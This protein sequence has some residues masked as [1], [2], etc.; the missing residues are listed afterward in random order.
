MDRFPLD[1]FF[2]QI[3]LHIYPEFVWFSNDNNNETFI[4]DLIYTKFYIA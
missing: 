2:K 3:N 4:Y 1:F